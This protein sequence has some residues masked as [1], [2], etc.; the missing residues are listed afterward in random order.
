MADLADRAEGVTEMLL[1]E[2]LHQQLG[3]SVPERHP[4][5]DGLH[6]VGCD[7]EIPPLRLANWRV[8]C[9]PCQEAHDSL[10]KRGLV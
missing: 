5:F 1:Q 10:A 6:C 3:K 2:S 4:D 8:R 7:E 9:V